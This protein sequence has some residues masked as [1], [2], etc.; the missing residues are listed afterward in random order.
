MQRR[1][2]LNTGTASWFIPPST[3][4]SISGNRCHQRAGTRL[5]AVAIGVDINAPQRRKG[6]VPVEKAVVQDAGPVS[7][8]ASVPAERHLQADLRWRRIGRQW[9][10]E[11]LNMNVIGDAVVPRLGQLDELD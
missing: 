8:P 3:A 4:T 10:V 5:K 7:G 6:G 11:I 9:V 2:R 1:P